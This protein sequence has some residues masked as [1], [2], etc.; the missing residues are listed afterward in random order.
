[1]RGGGSLQLAARRAQWPESGDGHRFGLVNSPGLRHSN[2]DSLPTLKTLNVQLDSCS[3]S[4]A[5]TSL[6]SE[7]ARRCQDV[8]VL[9]SV[10]I[11]PLRS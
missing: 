2:F 9:P 4:R 5:D 8:T 11:S 1:V 6:S 10:S 7:T 3:W